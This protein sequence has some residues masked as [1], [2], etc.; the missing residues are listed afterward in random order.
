MIRANGVQTENQMLSNLPASSDDR[1]LAIF[2]RGGPRAIAAELTAPTRA[3]QVEGVTGEAAVFLGASGRRRRM[4][5]RAR[6][7]IQVLAGWI[8]AEEGKEFVRVDLGEG[9]DTFHTRSQL[10]FAAACLLC[11]RAGVG[12]WRGVEGAGTA[13]VPFLAGA[14][15]TKQS[16]SGG[17]WDRACRDALAAAD[18]AIGSPVVWSGEGF[19]GVQ[20]HRGV[21]DYWSLPAMACLALA[22]W[23]RSL[24]A[25]RLIE[26]GRVLEFAATQELRDE[27][28]NLSGALA[29][30]MEG[31]EIGAT[32][33]LAL[34]SERGEAHLPGL[35]IEW[36]GQ[37]V[38]FDWSGAA[39]V[40]EWSQAAPAR[41][42]WVGGMDPEYGCGV[43]PVG[44]A[45]EW[46]LTPGPGKAQEWGGV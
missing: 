46:W 26:I 28:A 44:S 8:G 39:W 27:A 10:M 19:D 22:P 35:R 7:V 38:L 36:Q 31:V 40:G 43:V 12:G 16:Q 41:R 17:A 3:P 5:E 15:P 1:I 32:L 14:I 2:M 6:F 13:R 37:R 42:L 11:D 23:R 9:I 24:M 30:L 20:T 21:V 4:A 18:M 25:Q 29:S 34:P 33:P 45:D